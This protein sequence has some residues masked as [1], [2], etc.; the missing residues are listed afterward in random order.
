MPLSWQTQEL[1]ANPPAF[2]YY[3]RLEEDSFKKNC[4]IESAKLLRDVV[5]NKASRKKQ[6]CLQVTISSSSI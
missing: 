6:P 3:N 5:N 2:W 4:C 1:S